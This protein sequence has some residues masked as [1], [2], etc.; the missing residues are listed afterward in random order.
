MISYYII[1]IPLKPRC[2]LMRDIKGVDLAQREAARD[3]GE[4]GS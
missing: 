3:R 4:K 2:F 1:I